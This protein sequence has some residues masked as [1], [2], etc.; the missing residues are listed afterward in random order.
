[1]TSDS[2]SPDLSFSSVRSS[3]GKARSQM[4]QLCDLCSE[5][6]RHIAPAYHHDRCERYKRLTIH[7]IPLNPF[8]FVC[9]KLTGPSRCA[10]TRCT[11]ENSVQSFWLFSPVSAWRFSSDWQVIIHHRRCVIDRQFVTKLL[12][13][14]PFQVL[15]SR[16]L[17]ARSFRRQSFTRTQVKWLQDHIL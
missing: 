12:F 14:K 13:T 4:S 17:P 16:L 5:F 7:Q 6:S 15:P 2:V 1:M 9:N 11:N 8:I 10:C 3:L